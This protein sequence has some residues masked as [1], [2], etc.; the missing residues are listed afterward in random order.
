[1]WEMTLIHHHK[2]HY[3]HNQQ[4]TLSKS[5]LSLTM[6]S[7]IYWGIKKSFLRKIFP[8][9]GGWGG[10]F[11]KAVQTPQ[12]C[13]KNRLLFYPNF[14]FCFPISHKNPGVGG[15]IH[16][17]RKTFQ[18]SQKRFFLDVYLP[19]GQVNIYILTPKLMIWPP[20]LKNI[21]YIESLKHFVFV[22]VFVFQS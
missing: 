11:P 22:F 3:H 17:L 16:T 10:W 12:N 2:H 8:N 15:W 13:P 1:M 9:V 20:P 6:L 4:K 18:L 14:F 21:T 19:W 7:S 5:S